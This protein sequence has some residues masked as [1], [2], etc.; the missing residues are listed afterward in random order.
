MGGGWK[1]VFKSGKFWGSGGSHQGTCMVNGYFQKTSLWKKEYQ[2]RKVLELW[3]PHGGKDTCTFL[4]YYTT[5]N[6]GVLWSSIR[7]TLGGCRR[8]FRKVLFLKM[9]SPRS[10]VFSPL[11]TNVN[12]NGDCLVGYLAF[13]AWITNKYFTEGHLQGAWPPD[14]SGGH[15]PLP[16]IVS[17]LPILGASLL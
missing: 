8:E 9:S 6:A 2:I 7:T 12:P 3:R 10:F 15:A 17:C 1:K 11:Q 4:A 16:L 13:L 14:E 5:K